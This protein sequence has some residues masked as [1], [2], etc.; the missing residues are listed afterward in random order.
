M[1]FVSVYKIMAFKIF[2][3]NTVESLFRKFKIDTN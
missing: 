2:H 1:S 3:F